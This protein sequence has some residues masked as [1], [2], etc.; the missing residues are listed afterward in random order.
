MNK[1]NICIYISGILLFLF[2]TSFG[3]TQGYYV[4]TSTNTGEYSALAVDRNNTLHVVYS[5]WDPVGDKNSLMYIYKTVSMNNWS[6]PE[7]IDTY[8]N[9]A[10]TPVIKD[11]SMAIS[12]DDV[13]HVVYRLTRYTDTQYHYTKYVKKTSS[14][15]QTPEIVVDARGF[16]YYY[17]RGNGI[18]TDI[19][20]DPHIVCQQEGDWG[21]LIYAKRPEPGGS[22]WSKTIIEPEIL[23]DT[24]YCSIVLDKNQNPHIVYGVYN[25]PSGGGFSIRYTSYTPSTGWSSSQQIST[26][27]AYYF[28]TSIAMDNNEGIHVSYHHSISGGPYN[29]RY[30][31]K[32][33]NTSFPSY[34][35]NIEDMKYSQGDTSLALDGNAVPHIAYYVQ[36]YTLK[37]TSWTVGVAWSTHTIDYPDGGYWESRVSLA[38]DKDGRVFVTYY[39][40]I[41]TPPDT[42]YKLKIISSPFTCPPSVKPW[43][44]CNLTAVEIS[45]VSIKW[46]WSNTS[47]KFWYKI[48]TSTHGVVAN[49]SGLDGNMNRLE[50][51]LT[52]NTTYSRYVQV[53]NAGGFAN[54]LLV[55]TWTLAASP[56]MYVSNPV[57]VWTT[58]ITIRWAANG[59]PNYTQY[60]VE[61]D[62][63][64]P[65]TGG[66][67]FDGE[68]LYSAT[69]TS[70]EYTFTGLQ[71]HTVYFFRVRA[72]NIAGRETENL[73]L[74]IVL[75]SER[76][77]VD[78][79]GGSGVS[80]AVDRFGHFH[81]SYYTYGKLKYAYFDGV[82]WSTQ[83][84]DNLYP[85]SSAF[86]SIA[87]DANGT[88]HISYYYYRDL[89]WN[90]VW[91]L[92]YASRTASG[93]WSKS[94][95]DAEGDKGVYSSIAVDAL[96]RPHIAYIDKTNDDLK[97]AYWTGSSWSTSTVTTQCGSYPVSLA[98]AANGTPRITYNDGA[99]SYN[100]KYAY[101]SG[102]GWSIT[103]VLSL[104]YC[105]SLVLDG[106]DNPHI[107]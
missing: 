57:D 30:T 67:P 25:I 7:V 53:Y 81:I 72:K 80:L 77:V 18:V 106:F 60:I 88:P 33:V 6:A 29:L 39:D 65:G 31:S 12:P 14:G 100:L 74:P 101:W 40:Y 44:P 105:S 52:P 24:Y 21:R 99:T 20:G 1:Q 45:S 82:K 56:T 64:T 85:D 75:M 103:T 5:D 3:F 59:N 107:S 58:S 61:C 50:T 84:V 4:T 92:K 34:V 26:S 41:G 68:I 62:S 76:Q 73:L 28:H 102:T 83:T 91:D 22:G 97:Y 27:A 79:E 19:Y 87:V 13:I 90:Y 47:N 46:Q 66:S 32:T 2:L 15:W 51:G 69:T 93:Q 104:A 63:I 98:L 37:Y 43:Y 94:T 42:A 36:D 10:S 55:S 86:T 96:G 70:L 16:T 23:Y 9:L 54:S 35:S 48:L 11:I 17:G 38:F 8:T 78:T 95:V 89:G 71:N 49:I